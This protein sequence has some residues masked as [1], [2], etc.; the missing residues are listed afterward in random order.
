MPNWSVIFE[1]LIGYKSTVLLLITFEMKVFDFL[2]SPRTA[3]DLAKQLKADPRA[4]DI[5][6]EALWTLGYVEKDGEYY[7]NTS[8]ANEY[9]VSSSSAYLGDMFLLEGEIFRGLVTPET[10]RETAKLGHDPSRYWRILS[11]DSFRRVYTKV[12][13]SPHTQAHISRVFAKRVATKSPTVLEF[14]RSNAQLSE[15]ILKFF[16]SASVIVLPFQDENPTCPA[17]LNHM[18]WITELEELQDR[19]VDV[20]LIQNTI[21]YLSDSELTEWIRKL[22][23]KGTDQA[24]I[25]IHDFFVDHLEELSMNKVKASLLLDWITHGGIH[26]LDSTEVV[27]TL[28]AN[29]Y[30]LREVKNFGYQGSLLLFEKG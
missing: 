27:A 6:L 23:M 5:I 14:G 15:H 4:I 30:Q 19:C 17:T 9:L 22:A 2:K 21:H 12:V 11:D 25:F 7:F 24:R 16:P 28:R 20:V 3:H 8:F 18:K 29:C 13:Y 1:H 26:H 10:L